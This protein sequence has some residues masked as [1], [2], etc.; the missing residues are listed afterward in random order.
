MKHGKKEEKIGDL[1]DAVKQYDEVLKS[2][3]GNEQLVLWRHVG[4]TNSDD[5][6]MTG[7]SQ[8]QDPSR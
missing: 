1:R 7:S 6:P 8:T 4:G 5:D 3:P 2:E